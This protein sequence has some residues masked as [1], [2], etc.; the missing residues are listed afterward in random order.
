MEL[1]IDQLILLGPYGELHVPTLRLLQIQRPHSC[2][3]HKKSLDTFAALQDSIP[4]IVNYAGGRLFSGGEGVGK[5]DT[6]HYVTFNTLGEIDRYF[7]H[8]AHQGFI[9]P[10]INTGGMYS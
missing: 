5:Y 6:A 2:P 4:E 1:L 8:P 7:H 9:D 10:T 3:G